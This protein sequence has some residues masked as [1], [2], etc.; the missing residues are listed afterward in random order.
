M[1]VL[2][3]CKICGVTP[4]AGFYAGDFA[5]EC[6]N[7][8]ISISEHFND[9]PHR[10]FYNRAKNAKATA[11]KTWNESNPTYNQKGQKSGTQSKEE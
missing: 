10:R 5:I 4:S 9:H 8:E 6:D 11:I 2:N 1:T 7:C 3:P